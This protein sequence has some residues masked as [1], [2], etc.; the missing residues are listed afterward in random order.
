[1]KV[2][3]AGGNEWYVTEENGDQF[4]VI[5]VTSADAPNKACSCGGYWEGRRTLRPAYGELCPHMQAIEAEVERRL[6]ELL[7]GTRRGPEPEKAAV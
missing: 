1:M 2:E 3:H 6:K 4:C 5:R 7:A